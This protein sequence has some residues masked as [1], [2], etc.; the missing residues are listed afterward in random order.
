MVLDISFTMPDGRTVKAAGFAEQFNKQFESISDY[1]DSN[2]Y[3]VD[4]SDEIFSV[5]ESAM[6]K[7]FDAEGAALGGEAWVANNP[8]WA[9]F[10]MLTT[11]KSIVGQYTGDM[12]NSYV[13]RKN[14]N[15]VRRIEARAIVYGTQVD[16][17]RLFAK[18]RPLLIFDNTVR[19]DIFRAF[20][21][22]A[23][24]KSKKE[25]KRGTN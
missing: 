20:H 6:E 2:E 16:Y 21:R 1:L 14:T 4:I 12:K 11:G 9:A 8:E 15:A 25:L 13:D 24:N 22:A 18:R 19:N 10:K 7:R 5:L 23:V 17:A 3:Y